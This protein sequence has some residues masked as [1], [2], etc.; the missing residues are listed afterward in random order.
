MLAS[1]QPNPTLTFGRFVIGESNRLAHSAA[2][3]ASEVPG[4][5]YNP[6][7]IYGPSGCGKTHLLH[8]IAAVT[9]F[10]CSASKLLLTSGEAFTAAFLG[11]L[12]S[13]STVQFKTAVRGV[14]ALL[15][16]DV[17][18]IAGK[19][20]TEDE[21]LHAFNSITERGGQ[22]IFTF[23]RPPESIVWASTCLR[24]R[25]RSG[26]AVEIEQPDI[27][28]REMVVRR[29]LLEHGLELRD[30][31]L[32]DRL[33]LAVTDSVRS[34]QSAL[35][36]SLAY[37]SL[38]GEELSSTAVDSVLRAFYS[39]SKPLG[40]PALSGACLPPPARRPTTIAEVQALTASHF[41]VDVD[42]LISRR[43][44]RALTWPRQVAMYLARVQLG[45]P[46]QSI[47]RAFDGRDHA[48][49]VHAC[50][51]VRDRINADHAM[52]QQV[53][54]ILATTDSVVN[55]HSINI[56]DRP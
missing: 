12:Q 21:L 42:E 19:R 16:D 25:L 5:A 27:R 28:L 1:Q 54:S 53:E 56:N 41:N 11:A 15:I 34:L 55:P 43:R 39:A 52:R 14:D 46:L 37:A 18:F 3:T 38:R 50:K 45:A 24:E 4:G 40:D 26:L 22:V 9:T 13:R 23:D 48:T 49:V 20:R 47:G 8:A 17:A 31:T 10:S 51:R 33:A 30:N 7:L 29:T 35:M 6:L 44:S 36:R 2:L 32:V